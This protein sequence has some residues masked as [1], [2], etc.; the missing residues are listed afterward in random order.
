M[1]QEIL[2]RLARRPLQGRPGRHRSRAPGSGLDVHGFAA[3]ANYPDARRLDLRVSAR[4]PFGHWIVRLP[5]QRSSTTLIVLAD[6]SASMSFGAAPRKQDALADL[7]E[8]LGQSAWRVG[9][10]VGFVGA[11]EALPDQWTLAPTRSR[12]ATVELAQRLRSVQLHG[13]GAGAMELAALRF[14]GRRDALV[15]LVSDFHW[16]DRQLD[17]VC[18]ALASRDVVPVVLW[19]PHEFCDWPRRGLAELQDLESG[20]RRWIWFR[21]SLADAMA[22]AGARRRGELRQRFAQQGWRPFFCSGPFD[23]AALNA[24]F[25]GEDRN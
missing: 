20:E 22:R 14:G 11:D 23:A 12:G 16:P 3:L 10:A 21:P 17:A 25:H 13:Q 9:D 15:F 6:L 2:Y 24:Y 4:D 19:A 18:S 5:R 7:L 8:A 1:N